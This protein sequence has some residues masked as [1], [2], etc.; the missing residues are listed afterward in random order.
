M[1]SPD[2]APLVMA[3]VA[4]LLGGWLAWRGAA[5][6]RESI[7]R[8]GSTGG[9][10]AGVRILAVLEIGLGAALLTAGGLLALFG[11][12]R[13]GGY[14]RLRPAWLVLA[15]GLGIL[16]EGLKAIVAGPAAPGGT[17]GAWLDRARGLPA[18]IVGFLLLTGG[19]VDVLFPGAIRAFAERLI[20]MAP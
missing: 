3:L 5:Q 6:L 9:A 8:A 7:S 16:R 19:A 13:V 18:L 14:L 12:D 4:A 17:L 11:T 15:A 1:A 10:H 20:G 2:P